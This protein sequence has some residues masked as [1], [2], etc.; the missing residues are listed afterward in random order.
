[1]VCETQ[2]AELLKSEKPN[3]D[4]RGV[5]MRWLASSTRILVVFLIL[6]SASA[7]FSERAIA[8][9][10]VTTV[11]PGNDCVTST[12]VFFTGAPSFCN[13]TNGQ[14][15]LVNEGLLRFSPLVFQLNS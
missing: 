14:P 12:S 6:F 1:M 4:V 13:V 5:A 2:E 15:A 11:L 8:S 10:L 7:V 3:Y 9:A